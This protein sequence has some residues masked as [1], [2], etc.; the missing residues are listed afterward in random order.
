[1]PGNLWAQAI[2]GTGSSFPLFRGTV[3]LLL[4]QRER[5]GASVNRECC[6]F[7]AVQPMIE[8]FRLLRAGCHQIDV[9]TRTYGQTE[10]DS[11]ET[12]LYY[13]RDPNPEPRNPRTETRDPKRSEGMSVVRSPSS[14]SFCII[15][16]NIPVRRRY[17][18]SA[19][20][21]TAAS[22]PVEL[23]VETRFTLSVAHLYILFTA[24]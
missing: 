17:L 19:Q 3:K 15:Y 10:I 18:V 7:P 12:T 2:Q 8:N 23:Y 5:E 22:L 9:G 11:L 1:M 4:Y 16:S 21:S 20:C 24:D 13:S 6:S 14:V